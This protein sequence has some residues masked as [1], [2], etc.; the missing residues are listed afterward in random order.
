MLA[1]IQRVKRAQ[2]SVSNKLIS[3]IGQ[4]LLV[5]VGVHKSDTEADVVY[6][7]KKIPEL[8]IFADPAGKMNLSLVDIQGELLLVSQFT[9]C[10]DINSGR[11]PSFTE[12][13]PPELATKLIDRLV[14]LIK[15]Q[16]IKVQ[17]GEFAASMQVELVN[18]GP[19]TFILDSNNQK[20]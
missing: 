13:A 16:Q 4:G 5:L 7:S 1:V 6:L 11:R 18:D 19:V 14:D 20:K 8:R 9:L 12:A 2:V 10:A 17:T 15:A 3:Q